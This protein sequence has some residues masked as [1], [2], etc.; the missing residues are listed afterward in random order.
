MAGVPW[1]RPPVAVSGFT[2]L[3]VLAV[4]AAACGRGDPTVPDAA[5]ESTT[6]TTVATTSTVSTTATVTQ[7]PLP[8]ASPGVCPTIPA[9]AAPDPARPV[10]DVVANVD[11]PGGIAEGTVTVRFIPDLPTDVLVF[12]LWPAAPRPARAG[13]TV[14]TGAVTTD[15]GATLESIRPDPTSLH[16]AI[17]RTVA[18]GEAITVT[19]PFRVAVGGAVDDRVSLDRDTLRLGSFV[20]LLAWEPGVGWSLEP[21]TAGFAETVSSPAADWTLTINQTAGYDVLATGRRDPD[22]VWR[23]TALRDVAASFGHF[24]VVTSIEQLPGPVEVTVGV[25]RSVGEDPTA[26][27]NR[28]VSALRD[29]AQRFGP[30]PWDT[31]TLAI[32]PG[33]GGGIEF[34]TH[35]MQGPGTSG[36]TTPHEVAHMWFYALA[37]DNQ[38]RDPWLDEG[39]ASYAE[40]RHE[41]TVDA[42]RGRSIPSDA[43]GRV[44]APM[45]YWESH[46][47]SYYRGVY[48]QGAVAMASLG[49]LDLVDCALRLYVAREAFGIARPAALIEA[50]TVVFPDAA[51]QLAPFGITP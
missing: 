14:D 34:P 5:V 35:V 22:G 3:A 25:D 12:R 44:G 48:V 20:P 29:F 37:G 11:V 45:S 28:A 10:Y 41:G 1:R 36:R 2:A 7:P 9:P 17:G 38:G 49:R 4:L 39:L 33:L 47:D 50:M 13:T 23:G 27:L 16:V 32:T 19:V 30:Y 31:Y 42:A 46:L 15:A 43:R 26:Y 21:P 18:A 40:F 8:P 24:N 6:T 51:A